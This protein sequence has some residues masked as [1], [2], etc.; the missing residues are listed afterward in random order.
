MA[1]SE[2]C[3]CVTS[4]C[5]DLRLWPGLYDI[6][7]CLRPKNCQLVSYVIWGEIGT[8]FLLFLHAYVLRGT[9]ILRGGY[10]YLH[11]YSRRENH[12]R[13][14]LHNWACPVKRSILNLALYIVLDLQIKNK[15]KYCGYMSPLRGK[16]SRLKRFLKDLCDRANYADSTLLEDTGCMH[17]LMLDLL[18]FNWPRSF[19][20][21]SSFTSISLINS[22]DTNPF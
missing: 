20:K 18:G 2:N 7:L 4:L 15:W 19:F 10:P 9:Y 21:I 14:T 6:Y 12:S 5:P 17:S 16:G 3:G 22:S 11:L 1:D 8:L 13:G